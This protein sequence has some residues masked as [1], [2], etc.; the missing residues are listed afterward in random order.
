MKVSEILSAKGSGVTTIPPDR[1]VCDAIRLLVKER[2]GAVVVVDGEEIAGILS[3]R[4]VL[5]LTD[6]DP[7]RLSTLL[8]G[9][10]MTRDLVVGESGD[11]IDYVMEILTKN[12]IRHLPI[13]ENGRLA[14]ILSIGDVVNALRRG[15]EA[16]NRYMRDYVQGVVS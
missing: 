9:D 3:E 2:I 12:R 6:A 11:E 10:V 7:G 4:D 5:R 13:V 1:T 14:G 15:L 16:E 8:V